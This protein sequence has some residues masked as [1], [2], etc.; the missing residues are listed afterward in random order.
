M[1]FKNTTTELSTAA[2]LCRR[3]CCDFLPN[4]K[5]CDVPNGSSM[6]AGEQDPQELWHRQ[7]PAY[8]NLV[9]ATPCIGRKD[10]AAPVGLGPTLLEYEPHEGQTRW[11]SGSLPQRRE[12]SL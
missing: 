10:A 11:R 8:R 7:T 1:L 5:R 9:T 6:L 4:E 3:N 2:F 12:Q